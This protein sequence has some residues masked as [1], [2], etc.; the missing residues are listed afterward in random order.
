MTCLILATLAGAPIAA[1]LGGDAAAAAAARELYDAAGWQ[2]AVEEAYVMEP[3]DSC[4]I[5][6]QKFGDD[7]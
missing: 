5:R 2:V 6:R 1:E 7:A 4:A 3:G